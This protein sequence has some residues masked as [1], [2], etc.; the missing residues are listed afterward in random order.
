MSFVL[1]NVCE[2]VLVLLRHAIAH[3]SVHRRWVVLW[4]R[5]LGSLVGGV[6]VLGPMSAALT[7]R[8]ASIA[9]LL[10][11]GVGLVVEVCLEVCDE[12]IYR[13]VDDGAVLEAICDDVDVFLLN[14]RGARNVVE[15]EESR[16]LQ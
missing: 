11:L 2:G 1:R 6:G 10:L 4:C 3:S 7:A 12:P 8:R 5:P 14:G 13:F 15:H 16:L 9:L